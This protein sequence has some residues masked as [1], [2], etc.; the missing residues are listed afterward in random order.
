MQEAETGEEAGWWQKI[1]PWDCAQ[2][3]ENTEYVCLIHGEDD[4]TVDVKESIE[5]GEKLAAA[6]AAQADDSNRCVVESL[7]LQ[8]GNLGNGHGAAATCEPV[9]EV[10]MRKLRE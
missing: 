1:E 7:I 10:I 4:P 5:L 3:V 6:A 2:I 8:P 9:F